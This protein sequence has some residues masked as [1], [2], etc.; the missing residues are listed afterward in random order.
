MEDLKGEPH[1]EEAMQFTRHH[2]LQREVIIQVETCDKGGTYLGTLLL[3]GPPPFDL[4]LALLEKG[5]ASLHFTF[6]ESRPGGKALV[7]AEKMARENKIGIWENW[8]PPTEETEEENGTSA[9]GRRDAGPI[10]V[11]VTHI[12][13]G[14]NFFIQKLNDTKAPM[15]SEQLAAMSLS[16]HPPIGVR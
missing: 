12:V 10:P 13:D 8:K 7:A 16:D 9:K 14:S 15:I 6:D 2:L 1:G 3:Q 5:L 11:A 4:G